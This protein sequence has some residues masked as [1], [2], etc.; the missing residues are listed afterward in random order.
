MGASLPPARGRPPL[1]GDSN[2]RDSSCLSGGGKISLRSAEELAA[3]VL[4][5]AQLRA[6]V[7]G[8]GHSPDFAAGD[9]VASTRRSSHKQLPLGVDDRSGLGRALVDAENEVEMLAFLL[10]DADAEEAEALLELSARR[11]PVQ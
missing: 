3:V 8:S 7:E 1:Q 10:D 9:A 11:E 5:A 6:E 4:R 2:L